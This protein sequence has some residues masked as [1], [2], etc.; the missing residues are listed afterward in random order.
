MEQSRKA[1]TKRVYEARLQICRNWCSEHCVSPYSAPVEEIANFLIYLHEVKGCRASTLSGYRAA[2]ATVHKG[3]RK[4]SVSSEKNLT[5][6]IK[7]IFNSN[8]SVTPLLPNWDLP[9]VLWTLTKHPFELMGSI[10][11]KFF[12][13]KLYF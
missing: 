2:I 3:W 1:S 5:D 9:T 4:S 12:T 8:P 13:L 10:D 7:G 6:L 11:T